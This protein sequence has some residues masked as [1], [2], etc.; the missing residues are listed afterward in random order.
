[1]RAAEGRGEGGIVVDMARLGH[2]QQPSAA[3][4]SSLTERL[5]TGTC[6]KV[7]VVKL[8]KMMEMNYLR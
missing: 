1:M 3:L 4:P 8:S 5:R 6:G 7:K 2:L